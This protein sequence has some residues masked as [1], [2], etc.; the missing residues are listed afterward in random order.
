MKISCFKRTDDDWYGN[1]KIAD[2]KRHEGKG[3]VE[4]SLLSLG[5]DAK[6]GY[7]VCVWGN[8]DCGMERDFE[9]SMAGKSGAIVLYE[10]LCNQ[11]I[12]NKSW[13]KQEG[14]GYA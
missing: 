6:Y 10:L 2:D 3:Y 8:D 5:P 13:L 1:Y 14:F 12:I 9:S 7:R 4:V 11:V